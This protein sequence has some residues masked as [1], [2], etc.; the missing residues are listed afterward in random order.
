MSSDPNRPGQ[1]PPPP[2]P[3]DSHPPYP[4]RPEYAVSC[5][6]HNLNLL[7]K[8]IGCEPQEPSDLRNHPSSIP[9]TD[10]VTLQPQH[11]Q[12]LYPLPPPRSMY[13]GH[14]QDPYRGGP[15]QHMS[16]NQP[17]PRQRTA[18]AC[19]YCRRRKV[20][21]PV[22][23]R[24]CP[25]RK[26]DDDRSV[27]PASKLRRMAAAPTASVSSRN[28]SLPPSPLK[29]KPLCPRTPPT[30]ISATRA[31]CHRSVVADPSTRNKGLR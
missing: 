10:M 19:R 22:I 14:P 25:V 15:P 13:Q 29:R 30:R 2:S 1:Y 23:A 6:C 9:R 18:I 7:A 8:L 21:R 17:A 5:S 3:W 26:T 24:L 27:V 12:D 16:F 31:E 11:H 4:Q 20:I 28:A